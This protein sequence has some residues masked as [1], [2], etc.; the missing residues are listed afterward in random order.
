MASLRSPSGVCATNALTPTSKAIANN[1]KRCLC[2][3]KMFFQEFSF[4]NDRIIPSIRHSAISG[5]ADDPL[6]PMLFPSLNL[7]S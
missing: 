6:L 2:L 1:S 7:L 4:A 5:R 3:M